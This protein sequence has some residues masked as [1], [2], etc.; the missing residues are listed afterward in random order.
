ML[1]G[2]NGPM[3]TSRTV[4]E[5]QERLEASGLNGALQFLNARTPHRFTGVYRYDGD[6]LRNEALYDRF[7]PELVR[8]DDVPMLQAY[9]ALVRERGTGLMFADARAGTSVAWRPGT[10]VVSYCGALL[11]D[12]SGRPFG[13]LCHFDLDRCEPNVSVLE[14]LDEV[15]PLIYRWLRERQR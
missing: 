7:S 13:T 1:L 5:V 4:E 12:E 6:M 8:G 11:R 3:S 14:Q 2:D 9:C 15:A 10:P